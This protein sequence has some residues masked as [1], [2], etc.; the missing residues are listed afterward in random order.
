MLLKG[1]S[2]G[3]AP[4]RLTE[5]L[6]FC[7]FRATHLPGGCLRSTPPLPWGPEEICRPSRF[8]SG[9]FRENASDRSA[10]AALC[11]KFKLW[12]WGSS[13]GRNCTSYTT[14][15]LGKCVTPVDLSLLS[16]KMGMVVSRRGDDG[17]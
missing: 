17:P 9:S 1:I 4:K 11:S 7:V 10:L 8:Y 14:G 3:T 6:S 13:G 12:G 15:A 16:W 5:S 2:Q